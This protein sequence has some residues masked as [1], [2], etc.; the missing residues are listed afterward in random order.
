MINKFISL[1]IGIILVLNNT[2]ALFAAQSCKPEV[3]SYTIKN[4]VNMDISRIEMNEVANLSIDIIDKSLKTSDISTAENISVTAVDGSFGSPEADSIVITSVNN[5]TLKYTINFKNITYSGSGSNITFKI[6]YKNLNLTSDKI[7]LQIIECSEKEI[8]TDD[9]NNA[10]SN[11]QPYVEISR[12]SIPQPIKAN[13]EFTLQL[14]I[15]N[16]GGVKMKRPVLTISLP[17]SIKSMDSMGNLQIPDIEAGTSRAVT[18]RLSGNDYIES[19]SEQIDIILNYNYDS[20]ESG[21][22]SSTYSDRIF[23][24]MVS[25]AK[26]SAPI[27]QITRGKLK[28]PVKGGEEFTLPVIIKNIGTTAISSP[29][30][31]FTIPEEL[32]LLDDNS[33]AELNGIKPGEF[34]TYNLNLKAK[35]YITSSTQEIN[36]EL[37]YNYVSENSEVQSDTSTKLVVPSQPNDS[38]GSEPLLQIVPDTIE[39]PLKGNS[40]FSVK[41]AITN[42]GTAAISNGILNWEPGDG[43]I[44]TGKSS[45]FNIGT[46]KAGETKEI[47]VQGKIT[48]NP[49]SS[50]QI[51]NGELK[52]KYES[53]KRIEQGQETVKIVIPT[54]PDDDTKT[55]ANATPN[56]IVKHYNYGGVPIANGSKFNFDVSFKN[57]SKVTPIENIV[58]SLE[59]ETGLSITSASNTYY[60]EKLSAQGTASQAVEMQV[61]PSAE[62]GSVKLTIN[63]SYE[64]VENKERKQVTSSQNV[65]IPVYKPDKLEITLEPLP[66]ATVGNEQTITLNYVNKGKGELSNVRAEITGDITALTSVQNLGNFESGKSGT[67]TFVVIPETAGDVHFNVNISYEDANLDQKTLEFPC[68]MTVE[69]FN[70]DE[71]AMD[72]T[73]VED[74]N[75]SSHKGIIIGSIIGILVLTIIIIVIIKKRK[76]KKLAQTV[77]VNWEAED[78]NQGFN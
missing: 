73:P 38:E 41:V 59:T 77:S 62:T 2:A 7:S 3:D 24:P 50:S 18:L 75:S 16:R 44:L 40:K 1:I 4:S 71:F 53:S 61:L 14:I 68:I 57:T 26:T 67:I 39:N 22:T 19:N 69:E 74:E 17:D 33:S 5:D 52:Y 35:K 78:E 21:L 32:M 60:Y 9:P 25:T 29:L 30:L 46:L 51:I 49:A 63:F 36:T 58:M 20:N 66:T 13:E 70:D 12:S 10:Q 54:E 72:D 11:K 56:I 8:S 6:K 65:S 34:V 64:Y 37:K 55:T 27:I 15:K 28:A 43:I 42:A 31:S 23:I 47:K 76:K 45:S 48:A